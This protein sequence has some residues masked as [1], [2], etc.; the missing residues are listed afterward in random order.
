MVFHSIYFDVLW[1]T[2][3]LSVNWG[4]KAMKG[5]YLDRVVDCRGDYRYFGGHRR[6]FLNANRK[7]SRC[8]SD[9][10]AMDTAVR[11]CLMDTN[12]T[13]W[14]GGTTTRRKGARF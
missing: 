3:S 13:P 4:G 14:T 10:K 7:V 2:V 12:N 9:M 11:M 1:I 5:V 6:A 8:W